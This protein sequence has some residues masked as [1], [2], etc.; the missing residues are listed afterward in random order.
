MTDVYL[1]VDFVLLRSH[2]LFC[3]SGTNLSALK[4]EEKILNSS[5]VNIPKRPLR[6]GS[7]AMLSYARWRSGLCLSGQFVI[8]MQSS[9][10]QTNPA[11]LESLIQHPRWSA[12]VLNHIN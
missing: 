2:V 4:W 11:Q 10:A 7:I 8:L 9:P 6:A 1:S 12:A 5:F 3:F